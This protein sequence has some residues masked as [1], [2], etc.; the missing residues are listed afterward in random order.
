MATHTASHVD[1]DH[2]GSR[3][4]RVQFTGSTFDHVRFVDT[5]MQMVN[6][7][8]T[9]IRGAAMHR[10]RLSGVE[11]FDVVIDGDLHQVIVNGVD[12]APLVEAELDRRMPDRVLLKPADAAGYPTAWEMLERRWAETVERARSLPEADLHRSVDGEW[13][14]IQ[15]LRHLN[16][17]DAAWIDRMVI[18]TEAPYHPLDLPWDEAPADFPVPAD[19]A[20]RDAQPSL[21]EVLAI[22]RERQAMVRRAVESLTD[23]QLASTV[24]RTGPGWPQEENFPVKECFHI[25]LFEEWE[26][27]LFAERDLDKLTAATATATATEEN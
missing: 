2:S 7:S 8:G 17:A 4:E 6:L 10:M 1:E 15:T 21:D 22:R 13:S 26:H 11:L 24:T 16:F 23:E 14:F 19:R 5:D 9:T 25:A 3:F 27:R 20:G 18:G 12:I